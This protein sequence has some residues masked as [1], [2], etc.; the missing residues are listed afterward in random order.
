MSAAIEKVLVTGGAGRLGPFV[1]DEL[2]ERYEVTVLDLKAYDD[3][4]VRSEQVD[5]MDL[6][7]LSKVVEGQDAIVHLAGID[8][9][10]PAGMDVIM[11][12]NVLGT[13]NVL[14]AAEQARV[15]KVLIA[16]SESALGGE[17]LWGDP[18]LVYLPADEHHP[19]VPTTSYALSMQLKEETGRNFARR[20]GMNVICLRP[21]LIVFPGDEEELVAG[22]EEEASVT[23]HRQLKTYD[24]EVPGF[25]PLASL[26]AY[27][28]ASDTGRC[29]RLALEAD[30]GGGFET[31][32]VAAADSFEPTATLDF[33]DKRFGSLPEVRKPGLYRNN[34]R[35]SVIDIAAARERLG[36]QPSGSW[37][38][39]L[40][41]VDPD[42]ARRFDALG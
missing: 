31:Y 7:A 13:W 20:A 33:M 10:V 35:A 14:Y 40:R 16:S 42:L 25:E 38:E 36:W 18:P 8:A 39:H 22:V 11:R 28:L 34:P 24:R 27:V 30:N 41:A 5:M 32:Y 15:G 21:S 23:D 9:D 29:F 37:P 4:K 2:K 1:V 26:R 17:V 12:V 3:P 6:A 19:L